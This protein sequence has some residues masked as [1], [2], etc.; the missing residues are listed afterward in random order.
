M[1]RRIGD[2]LDDAGCFL[3]R[4]GM[5]WLA[6]RCMSIAEFLDPSRVED[7]HGA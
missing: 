5:Y 3:A 2:M 6:A 1:L 7:D 4:H